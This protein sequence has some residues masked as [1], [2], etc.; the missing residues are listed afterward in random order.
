MSLIKKIS[1]GTGQQNPYL[2]SSQFQNQQAS[3]GNTQN[4][5][6]SQHDGVSIS[7]KKIAYVSSGL[8]LAALG[9]STI[10]AVRAGKK[11]QVKETSVNDITNAVE[12]ALKSVRSEV[13]ELKVKS[14]IDNKLNDRFNSVYGRINE[15]DGSINSKAE[16][17][18]NWLKSADEKLREKSEFFVGWFKSLDERT[19]GL[20]SRMSELSATERNIVK[21][22]NFNLL[23]NITSD[24]MRLELP[25]AVKTEISTA[26]S[27]II[28]KGTQ[29]PKL[30]KNSTIWSIT[31]ES[32]PEKEG[33]LG[34]VPTQI[35]KN[36]TKEL[37]ISNYLVRPINEI[38]G[39]STII[40]KDGKWHY[41]YGK[42]HMDVDKIAEFEVY[43]FRNGRSEK[44]LVEVFVGNDPDFGFKRL[45]FRNPDYF[46]ANGL[47]KDSQRASEKER[48]AFLVKS[49][50]EF[51]KMKIDPNS[52]TSY[53]I[54]NEKLFNET[55]APDAMLLNDWHAAGM[56]GLTKL[57]APAEAAMGELSKPAAETLKKMNLIEIIHNAD[58]QGQDWAHAA[59][60]L[61]TLYGKYAYDIYTLAK[62]GLEPEGLKNVH[63]ID[64][65]IN[66][67]NISASLANKLK[68]VSRSYGN[69]LGADFD[70]GHSLQHIYQKRL[71]EGTMVGQSNGWDRSVNEVSVKNVVKFNDNLNLDKFTILKQ[72]ID[73]L[74]LTKSQKEIIKAVFT[75][76]KDKSKPLK[77]TYE[78]AEKL[79]QQLK[80]LNF[81]KLNEFLAKM[82]AEGVTK[83]R[84]FEPEVHTDDIE[85][86]MKARLHNKAQ[87]IDLL[88]SMQE[89]NKTHGQLFNLAAEGVTD[90]SKIDMD[91]LDNQIVLNCGTRFVSQK[92]V[93]I[94]AEVM[95]QVFEEWPARYPGKPKPIFPVG[96][97]DGE[98]GQWEA[99]M[100]GFKSSMGDKAETVPYMV[101]Y[102]P[103]NVFHSGSDITLYPSHFE[104]DG[105]KWESLYKGTPVVATRVGGHIDSIVDGY[106]GYLTARTV[107]EVKNSGYDYLGT[108]VY[109]FKQAIFRA[110]DDFFNKDKW[111]EMVRHSIDGDQSWLI[112]DKDGR[113][114]G[115]SL[116]GHLED[117]GFN[118]DDFPKIA[119]AETRKA[120]AES[121]KVDKILPKSE[122]SDDLSVKAPKASKKTTKSKKT[123][124]AGKKPKTDA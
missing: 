40:E 104:P 34:E 90:L 47:Y 31:M 78:N 55:P 86:I 39:T 85:T 50:Y 15:V 10:A 102:T 116:L 36:M 115:G 59:D 54:F 120:F 37:D 62:T 66:L 27:K 111:K 100:R 101:G 17:F 35:A 23:Q 25:N 30:D 26:A 18:D 123:S 70:R 45:M 89:Y 68:P 91:D 44:E 32:I 6:N 2:F 4:F 7:S 124:R 3:S 75:D 84:T 57:L 80:D 87:F 94:L 110:C 77:F 97:A 29:I 74:D 28:N 121:H 93:N 51:A 92:G 106:N 65:S 11:P 46:M 42:F 1:F 98:T 79:L 61:N 22:D 48:C 33:G 41:K 105:S 52:R 71:D 21:I 73:S 108:M 99:L 12:Q 60:I 95:K 19:N 72:G 114:V 103:N 122:V 8:A 118:L 14:D 119:N 43:A 107:P 64:G 58:Y 38:P 5:Q 20:M 53:R 113:I 96:G 16:W 117:L 81:D 76:P 49:A 82:D 67:A 83:L 69:E 13:A 112:K 24:G 63:V 109:D 9:V 88:K 56:A